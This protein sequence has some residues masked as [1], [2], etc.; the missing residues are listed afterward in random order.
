MGESG[1][2][3]MTNAQE[4]Q[5]EEA[6]VEEMETQIDEAETQME[7]EGGDDRHTAADDEVPSDITD[8][9]TVGAIPEPIDIAFTASEDDEVEAMNDE[10]GEIAEADED[11]EEGECTSDEEPPPP[12]EQPAPAPAVEKQSSKEEKKRSRREGSKKRSH[13][14][15]T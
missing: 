8:T 10:A 3:E 6:N 4:T 14:S 1:D 13:R 9:A 7:E 5:M 2:K 15:R 12:E 11:L